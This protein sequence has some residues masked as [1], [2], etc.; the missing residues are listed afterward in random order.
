MFNKIKT[1]GIRLSKAANGV[2]END[3]CYCRQRRMFAS[4]LVGLLATHTVQ[5]IETSDL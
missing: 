5:D 3:R 4:S 2:G 1:V